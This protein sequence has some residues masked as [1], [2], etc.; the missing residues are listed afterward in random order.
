MFSL[1]FPFELFFTL[2]M[3]QTHSELFVLQIVLEYE[4]VEIWKCFFAG[5]EIKN[6]EPMARLFMMVKQV[7][8]KSV[9]KTWKVY[10]TSAHHY[11]IILPQKYEIELK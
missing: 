11:I 6:V 5:W 4:K 8:W 7:E 3:L 1:E 2:C 9:V 10:S